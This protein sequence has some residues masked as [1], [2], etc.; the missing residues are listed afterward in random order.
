MCESAPPGH[1][2]LVGKRV[3]GDIN[4]VCGD[5]VGCFTCG[6]GFAR[7][8]NHCPKRTV[9]GIVA[10]DGTYQE[11]LT[12]PVANLHLV[13]DGVSTENAV[14]SPQRSAAA[15][16]AAQPAARSAHTLRPDCAPAPHPRRTVHP[17]RSPSRSPPPSASSSSSWCALQP[18]TLY[19]KGC[20]PAC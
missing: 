4:L 14:S 9:L 1:E 8:R 3:V 2:A 10:K 18:F 20:N 6:C 15:Q 11:R 16:L 13:P 19:V 7:A 17:R 12:L 5:A